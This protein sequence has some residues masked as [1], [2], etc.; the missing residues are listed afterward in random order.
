MVGLK[1]DV[2]LKEVDVG[3]KE[4]DVGL[5]EEDVGLNE[6]DVG[7]TVELPVPLST[8]TPATYE[9]GLVDDPNL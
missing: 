1:D 8:T 9:I 7:L 5:N 6:E 4:V 3:L 2:G